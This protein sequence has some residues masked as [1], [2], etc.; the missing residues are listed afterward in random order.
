MRGECQALRLWNVETG[1]ETCL[2]D[3]SYYKVSSLD[4]SGNGQVLVSSHRNGTI[5]VWQQNKVLV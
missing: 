4:F 1:N 3:Q 2:I 5:K